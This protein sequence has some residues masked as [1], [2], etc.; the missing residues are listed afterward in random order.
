MVELELVVELEVVGQVGGFLVT[1]RTLLLDQSSAQ[2]DLGHMQLQVVVTVG[3]IGTKLTLG[4]SNSTVDLF[5]VNSHFAGICESL[6]TLRARYH[7]SF[8]TLL[9]TQS[10]IQMPFQFFKNLAAVRTRLVHLFCMIPYEMSV[11]TSFCI[12]LVFTLCTLELITIFMFFR[13]MGLA[14]SL[15]GEMFSTIVTRYTFTMC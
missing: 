3:C 11:Q 9:T 6:W 4:V 13:N 1:M 12:C 8:H 7:C 14:S 2:V 10:P 15:V 5:N